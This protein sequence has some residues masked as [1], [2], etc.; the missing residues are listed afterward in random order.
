MIDADI[1]PPHVGDLVMDA[2]GNRFPQ[3]LVDE[4]I[5]TQHKHNH[6]ERAGLMGLLTMGVF[7]RVQHSALPASE[8]Q[9]DRAS[10]QC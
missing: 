9:H 1:A 4:I 7:I 5:H 10:K 3:A 8:L 2:V 6:I